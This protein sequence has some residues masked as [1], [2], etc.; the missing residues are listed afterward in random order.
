VQVGVGLVIGIQAAKKVI[1]VG[2]RTFTTS[3]NEIWGNYF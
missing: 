2:N 3:F 1:R